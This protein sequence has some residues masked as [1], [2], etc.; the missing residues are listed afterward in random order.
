MKDQ[1]ATEEVLAALFPGFMSD[2]ARLTWL[3]IQKRLTLGQTL[4][5]KVVHIEP[6]GVFA[7]VGL[8]FPALI[9]VTRFH[10][11]E[12]VRRSFA[13]EFPQ[14]GETIEGSVYAFCEH[15]REIALTQRPIE[16]W[17]SDQWR[18]KWGGN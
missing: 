6:F 9:L 3:M 12:T 16:E 8:G 7:D 17:M 13:N 2:H 1:M 11:A 4:S 15:P 18:I 5:G 10:D 14:I